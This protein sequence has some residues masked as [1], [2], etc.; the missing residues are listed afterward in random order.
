MISK[1]MRTR[2]EELRM[3]IEPPDCRILHNN[4]AIVK[5]SARREGRGLVA[6]PML[7]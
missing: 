7:S 6:S 1:T 3:D 4:V 5:T 2:R